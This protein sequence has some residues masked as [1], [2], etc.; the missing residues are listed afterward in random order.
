MDPHGGSD[1]GFM[2]AYPNN[3]NNSNNMA[4]MMDNQQYQHQQQQH[5]YQNQKSPKTKKTNNKGHKTSK[6][7]YYNHRFN[8]N[9]P[10]M[11]ATPSNTIINGFEQ[12]ANA[13]TASTAGSSTASSNR[14]L[15]DSRASRFN[16]SYALL[17]LAIYCLVMSII[18]IIITFIFPFMLTIEIQPWGSAI[19]N[20]GLVNITNYANQISLITNINPA[21]NDTQVNIK[22]DM[23]IW[24]VKMHQR[25]E[26]VD[27]NGVS[28]NDGSPSML[29]LSSSGSQAFLAKFAQFINLNSGNLFTIQILSIMH[30]LFTILAFSFTAL[31]LC[32]CASKRASLCWYLA[33]F[34][35]SLVSM[36]LGLA[37]I[38]LFSLWKM[39]VLPDFRSQLSENQSTSKSFGWCFW[40]SVGA[41]VSILVAS[42]HILLYLLIACC[43]YNQRDMETLRR[44][45]EY[46][47]VYKYK[48]TIPAPPPLRQGATDNSFNKMDPLVNGNSNGNYS[49]ALPL[50]GNY[51]G[52]QVGLPRVFDPLH[53]NADMA[54]G[55]NNEMS[56]QSPSYIFYT[57]HGNYQKKTLD[58]NEILLENTQQ[59]G[60]SSQT[61]V[62]SIPTR[63]FNH[64]ISST[65]R[66]SCNSIVNTFTTSIG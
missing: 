23:G 30:L 17:I 51:M 13:P 56:L 52:S 20:E 62:S 61:A 58:P 12:F 63:S 31:T 36:L 64:N 49:E 37:T 5:H 47:Y 45:K 15:I 2:S 54:H 1:S 39:S 41:L 66:Y 42:L 43:V 18:A 8:K 38:I 25:L 50:D 16:C 53:V 22:F 10:I 29:W 27:A 28:S 26:L 3:A 34:F 32:L 57:G 46:R 7:A 40:V 14:A 55:S 21:S 4:S 6:T 24:E 19:S 59:P 9:V 60:P 11:S 33:C 65:T 35:L 44:P 48:G